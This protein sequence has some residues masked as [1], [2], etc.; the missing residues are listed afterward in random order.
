MHLSYKLVDT[1]HLEM[2]FLYLFSIILFYYPINAQKTKE[3]P[4]DYPTIKVH[5]KPVQ[6]ERLLT[7]FT[8]RKSVE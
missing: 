5:P 6:E 4:K 7:V 3:T 2:K 1:K 8:D